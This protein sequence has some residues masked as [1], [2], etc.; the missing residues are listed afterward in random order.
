VPVHQRSGP[1]DQS[2]PVRQ[3]A[4]P[5]LLDMHQDKTGVQHAHQQV[6]DRQVTE[7]DATGESA[8]HG[9]RTAG[10]PPCCSVS[11]MDNPGTVRSWLLG[12]RPGEAL[13]WTSALPSDPD[14]C[15]ATRS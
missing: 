15:L 8:N 11:G 6:S 3:I 7:P 14:R 13:P 4:A 1:C 5:S 10:T 2:K 9:P 12:Q